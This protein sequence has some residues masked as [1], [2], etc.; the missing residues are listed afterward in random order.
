[1]ITSGSKV[2][3]AQRRTAPNSTDVLCVAFCYLQSSASVKLDRS[4]S[5]VND[6]YYECLL[7]Y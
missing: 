6:Y 3:K 7:V 2:V 5:F 4:R 1:M